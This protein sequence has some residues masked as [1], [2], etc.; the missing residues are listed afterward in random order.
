MLS[1]LHLQRKWLI[2]EH[3]I[4][5]NLMKLAF[6]LQGEVSYDGVFARFVA[7]NEQK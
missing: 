3:A 1:F 5:S 7:P 4:D 2:E 6:E